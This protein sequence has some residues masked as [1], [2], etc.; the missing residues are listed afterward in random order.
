M[1]F[2]PKHATT[3]AP[4]SS[5]AWR[6]WTRRTAP[7]LLATLFLLHGWAAVFA[8]AMGQQHY[9]NP[10]EGRFEH[11]VDS[12]APFGLNCSDARGNFRQEIPNAAD[13]SA[14]FVPDFVHAGSLFE[15]AVLATRF[16][17]IAET[18]AELY[19]PPCCDHGS[20]IHFAP[21]NSPPPR[22]QSV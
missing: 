6:R 4:P 21:K 8:D 10:L 18:R 20:R 11:L 22:S 5:A 12:D 9:W 14:C 2:S 1:R 13:G 7:R 3:S 16:A 17:E 19:A 15:D